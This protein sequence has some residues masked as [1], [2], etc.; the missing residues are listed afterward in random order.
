MQRKLTRT[1]D[2]RDFLKISGLATLGM[3][4]CPLRVESS[5]PT[6]DMVLINGKI[7]I[8]D[9]A[10][11]I[12]QAVAV[13]KGTIQEVGDNERVSGCIGP[14]TNV[15]DLKGKTVTP[16]LVDSHAHLPFFGMRENGWFVNLQGAESKHEIME[17]LA[18]RMRNTPAGSW[19]SAWGIESLSLDFLDKEQLD[20]LSTRHPMLVVHTGGQWGFANSLALK[21]AGIDKNTPSPPGSKIVTSHGGEPTGLLIHYPALR[22]V[23]N[24]MP[25]P[26]D[27]QAKDALLYAANLYAAEGVTTVHDNFFALTESHFHKAYFELAQ[28]RKMPLRIKLWPYM[29]N[30]YAASR[31]V[32]ALFESEARFQQ[33]PLKVLIKYEREHPALF[34]SLWGGFKLAVDGGGRTAMWYR[35][36]GALPLHKMDEL[37]NMVC[38]FHRA[39]HQVS[40]HAVGDKAV[41]V[42][43]DA[44]ETAQRQY[45]R[46]NPRH[47]IEHSLSPERKSLDRMKKLGIV[48][49]TH[50]QWLFGWGDKAAGLKRLD[51]NGRGVIPVKSY[52]NNDIPLA[53]GADPPAFPLYQP[54]VALAGAV[55]RRTR[56]GYAFDSG[57]SVSIQK[58]LKCQTM[59]SAYAG[60]QEREIGSIE[61][62]KLADL[63]VWDRDLYAVSS[64]EIQGVKAEVTMVG[65][66]IVYKGPHTDLV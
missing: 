60:F 8:M 65:G 45:P 9:R 28:T 22:L 62:G 31:V 34:S 32:P 10:D 30:F 20:R 42:I 48:V 11:S 13:R 54:Q 55:R 61:Q 51:R 12:A 24:R 33:S 1:L 17:R 44:F 38:L 2:R 56:K 53:F 16:G 46:D 23:R 27:A 64:A 19:I 37:N 4:A 47:R 59:G 6:A 14:G 35:N 3:L 52:L 25:V 57:E 7:I 18:Q 40:V 63:V 15:I 43:L 36:P 41:D 5:Y 39:G 49:S 29:P 21:M 26:D 50:P 66:E 58:A